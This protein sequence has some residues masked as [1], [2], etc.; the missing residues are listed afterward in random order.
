MNSK[1]GFS[2]VELLVSIA[3]ISI[4]MAALTYSVKAAMLRARTQKALADVKAVTEAVLGYENYARDYE[5]PK[6]DR[7]ECDAST[8]KFLIG[9]G[10]SS[11]GGKLPVIL[12]AAFSTNGKMIDPWGR[13]YLI[14]IRE[15]GDGS[16]DSPF[17]SL[18]SSFTVPNFYHLTKEER[19]Q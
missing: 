1:R 12:Q 10:E 4:L 13:P 3:M 11:R 14:T 17:Q 16:I 18:T 5:L 9:D 6:Y 7:V 8:L 2:L 15:G 19:A